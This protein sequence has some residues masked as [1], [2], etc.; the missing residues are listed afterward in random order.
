MDGDF[1]DAVAPLAEE[2]VGLPNIPKC[3]FVREQRSE[4]NPSCLHQRDQPAHPLLSARTKRGDD[5]VIAQPR[6]EGV[7]RQLELA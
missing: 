7:V 2:L 5:L 6:G 1:D 4:I 3:E